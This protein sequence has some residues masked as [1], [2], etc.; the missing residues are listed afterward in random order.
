MIE[1]KF[2]FYFYFL[3]EEWE[4]KKKERKEKEEKKKMVFK[5][6]TKKRTE[7]GDKFWD[8]F[9]CVFVSMIVLFID[10]FIRG[11]LLEMFGIIR[12]EMNNTKS[13]EN[14]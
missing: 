8:H 3:V 12:E 5:K 13:V 1:K 2:Y 14:Q 9:C 11:F 4:K 7:N 6:K 10:V